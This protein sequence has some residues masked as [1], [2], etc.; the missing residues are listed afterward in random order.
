MN[1]RLARRAVGVSHPHT[2]VG[3]FYQSEGR[4]GFGC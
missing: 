3:Y 1:H 4:E 2:P